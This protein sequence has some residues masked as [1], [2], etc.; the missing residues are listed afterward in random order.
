MLPPLQGTDIEEGDHPLHDLSHLTAA[1]TRG[2]VVH[3]QCDSLFLWIY[4]SLRSA[5]RCC[6]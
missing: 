3:L 6:K 4:G 1:F 5:L 2:S